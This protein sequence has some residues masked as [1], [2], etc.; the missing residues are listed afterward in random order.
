MLAILCPPEYVGKK[1]DEKSTLSAMISS[2]KAKVSNEA[3]T[4]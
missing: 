4:S 2:T 1:G 3:A